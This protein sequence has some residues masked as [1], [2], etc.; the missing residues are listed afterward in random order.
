MADARILCVSNLLCYLI[1]KRGRIP[2]KSLKSLLSDFYESDDVA[3][4]KDSLLNIC[5]EQKFDNIPKVSRRRRESVG[6][7]SL[8]I[9]DLFVLISFCDENGHMDKLPLFVSDN[10]D[11][12]PSARLTEGDLEMIWAKLGKIE[13]LTLDINGKCGGCLD[14][15]CALSDKVLKIDSATST[16][17]SNIER[18]LWG[19]KHLGLSSHSTIDNN[20]KSYHDINV[21]SSGA[22]NVLYPDNCDVGSDVELV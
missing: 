16:I 6:K 20:A 7:L 1:N 12:M 18:S 8:D 13:T 2:A 15:V 9:D 3:A 14:S 4:A 10:P 19:P 21:R 17:G 22:T 5:D 11:K